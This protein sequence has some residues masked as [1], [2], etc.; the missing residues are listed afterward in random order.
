VA[1]YRHGDLGAQGTLEDVPG[2]YI[3]S[4]ESDGSMTARVAFQKAVQE[5]SGR[6]GELK[7]DIA[8]VM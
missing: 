8:T 5:L 3:L 7:E 6:F 1:R 4:F 2:E